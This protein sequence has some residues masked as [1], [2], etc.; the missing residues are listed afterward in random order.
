MEAEKTSRPVPGLTREAE[1]EQLA[2]IIQVAQDNLVRT[3]TYIRQ[4]TDELDDLME[5]YGTK[6]KEA[7]ALLHN[8]HSQIQENRRDLL[9]CQKA[10]KKPYFGRI[11]FKDEKQPQAESYYI[12][13]TGIAGSNAHPLVIDWRAPVASVYYE[14]AVGPCTYTVK[15]EGRFAI[16]LIRKRT[17]EIEHDRLKDF[18][19]SDVVANDDLLTQY[20]A[21]S[22]KAVLGEIIATIQKEQNAM[23]RQSPKTNLIVQGV[24]GSGKTTVAMHRISYIL[25]NYEEQFRPQDFYIIGSNRIL[26]NYITGVL[27]ELDVYGVSQMTMEELFTRL[28]YEDWDPLHCQIRPVDK[29]ETGARMKGTLEWFHELEQFCAALEQETIP[30]ADVRVPKNG[31]LLLKASEIDSYLQS[32]GRLSMQGRICM[33]NEIL[34]SRL[35]TEMSGKYV[36]YTAAEK[37]ELRRLMRWHFG[38]DV[39]KGS[40][41]EVYEWFLQAQQQKGKAVPYEESAFDVYD[42]A[43]L[44]YIYKRIKETDGIRE[45][46]HVII[47]EAQ[48]FGMMAYGVLEYCLRGCTYTIMGDVSQNIHFGY[49]LNDWRQLQEL[50]LTGPYDHFGLLKKSYRNTVEISRFAT[51]ILRHGNFP[52]YPVEP[53]SRHGSDVCVKQ[54]GTHQQM[55]R[56]MIT[57]IRSWQ[58][59]GRE[60]IAVICKDEEQA[61]S[62]CSM[63][64][65]DIVVADSNLQTAEFGSG[66]MVLPV[67]YTKGLEF[68]AVLLYDPSN[69]SYPPQ[70]AYVKLLYVAATRALHELEVVHLG[71]LTDLIAKPVSDEK[72]MQSLE[73]EVR[74]EAVRYQKEETT[75]REQE[76][77]KARQGEQ[78]RIARSFF[79][80]K[81]IQVRTP[82]KQ[83][84]FE[85]QP[86]KKQPPEKQP[87]KKQPP[88]IPKP[89]LNNRQPQRKHQAPIN[90]SSHRFGEC[91]DNALL[92]PKGHGR[93]DNAV[94]MVRKTKQYIECI[95]SYG[96]LRLTPICDTVIRVQFRKGTME[97]FE[98][99]YW[100]Q[101]PQQTDLWK[102]KDGKNLVEAQTDSLTVRID[103]KTGAL[104]FYDRQ[105]KLLL[106]E[107][108]ALPRQCEMSD[109]EPETWV[110]FEWTNQEPLFAKGL[111]ADDLERINTKARY[112]SFGGKKMR[113][114]LLVSGRGYGIGVAASHTVMCCTIPM[115]GN[116]IYTNGT[117]QIDYY[118]LYGKE[119]Q[120]VLTLYQQL[121][122]LCGM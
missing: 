29:K 97:P 44:A 113:M 46:T 59:D 38:K 111:L 55:I 18:Y 52:V 3:Q 28:L 83:Q 73:N 48:D 27:P 118:F 79:G 58:K 1:E 106:A 99:G 17:Y 47:D 85:K 75:A 72:R 31:A 9:R 33:L 32:M 45:A 87:P 5:V 8:T 98:T 90:A 66:V 57:R 67:A 70:D 35:D 100:E 6:D 10:R 86:I 94:R 107:K 62:V 56:E 34:L 24:A 74:T 39:W 14:N 103:K 114:P 21:K 91:P 115:Y 4:L 36:T 11:D 22:K 82:K 120:H 116:Y 78:E 50:I 104:Q 68:D 40:V 37:K 93:I 119:P 42:L 53:I 20:L 60:T 81:P 61:A 43:A 49:G 109:R 54:C 89:V 95:G 19:D 110:F 15:N 88:N 96:T 41:Y 30:K 25:Y 16:D 112:I 7:L 77:L 121:Q 101:E 69:D 108:A 23:I 63:L 92:Q 80:P 84:S 64:E 76:L 13:R 65:P 105:Q 122:N 12:G 117:G 102:V 71:N 51:E 2:E 26:L